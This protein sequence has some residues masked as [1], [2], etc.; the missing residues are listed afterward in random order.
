MGGLNGLSSGRN[1]IRQSKGRATQ[2]ND[3]TGGRGRGT[4]NGVWMNGADVKAD[5]TP[6]M[7][8]RLP[9]SVNAAGLAGPKPTPTS[10]KRTVSTVG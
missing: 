10:V 5:G 4:G 9:T 2:F 6:M 8:N 3:G 1:H 7:T